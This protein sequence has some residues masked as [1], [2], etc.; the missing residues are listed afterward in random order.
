MNPFFC[1]ANPRFLSTEQKLHS[2][3]TPQ[4]FYLSQPSN[5]YIQ[6]VKVLLRQLKELSNL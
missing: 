3:F 4:A 2:F 6:V 1:G 5:I